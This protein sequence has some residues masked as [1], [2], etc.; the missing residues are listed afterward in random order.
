MQRTLRSHFM[1]IALLVASLDASAQ[2]TPSSTATSPGF[3][4]PDDSY[5]MPDGLINVAYS[6]AITINVP[7]SVKYSGADI[8]VDSIQ[9]N[10]VTNFPSGISAGSPSKSILK[11]GES[12]C[13]PVSGTTTASWEDTIRISY[14][15]Y[16]TFFSTVQNIPLTWDSIILKIGDPAG[17]EDLDQTRFS[18]GQNYP[19]PVV[20]RTEIYY[21]LPA[22]A[23]VRFEVFDMIG[24][25]VYTNHYRGHSGINNIDFNAKTLKP[26]IY[27]YKLTSGDK[28]LTR[29]M[30][31]SNK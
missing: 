12:G 17:I 31:L 2:C 24:K 11:G 19:N 7:T 25:M 13:I 10:S 6:S 28:A 3:R 9:I 5:K 14:N 26:G 23:D 30:V 18:V 8:P 27:V 1:V 22:A 29:R 20:D 21:S 15:A 4:A 16:I